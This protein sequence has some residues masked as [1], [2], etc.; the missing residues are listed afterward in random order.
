MSD[1]N[2]IGARFQHPGPIPVRYLSTVISHARNVNICAICGSGSVLARVFSDHLRGLL[3]RVS[4]AEYFLCG[5]GLAACREVCSPPILLVPVFFRLVRTGSFSSRAG[6]LLIAIGAILGLI[7]IKTGTP[8]TEWNK[9]YLHIV[10]S[11]A[12]VGLLIAGWLGR[13]DS[14]ESSAGTA[15]VRARAAICLA[16]L[17]GIG[18]GARYVRE[19][20]Q[21]RN[22]IQNPAMPP[23]NMNGEGDG[24]GGSVLPELGAGLREA[25]N[26]Q[27]VFS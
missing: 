1:N 8:R 26:S 4:S 18:Y 20:W 10:I 17:A 11:L 3:I 24:P 19:S 15:A 5:P 7:L 25:E 23:D 22:R 9:L 21:T 13:R 6:W 16:V 14:T 12:G 27:Q 2:V